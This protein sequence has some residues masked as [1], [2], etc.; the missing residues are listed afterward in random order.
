MCVYIIL[1]SL[2][3]IQSLALESDKERID[4]INT[5]IDNQ[6]SPMNEP[7]F[8]I[9]E[10]LFFPVRNIVEGLGGTIH[11]NP[12]DEQI[13]IETSSSDKLLF[14]IGMAEIQFNDHKYVM[15]VPSFI[16]EDR[17]YLPLRHVAEFMHAD[18]EWDNSSLTASLTKTPFYI[19]EEGDSLTSISTKFNTT[20]SLLLERNRSLNTIFHKGDI[21]KVLI[22]TIMEHKIVAPTVTV[23]TISMKSHPDYILLSKIIQVEAGY[24]SYESQV[25]VG[26]VIM[27]RVKDERFPNSIKEVIYQK[28]QFPPAHNGLLDESEPNESVL[29]AAEAVWNGENNVID[30]LY[31]YNPEV[32]KSI[33]WSKLTLVKEI[34]HHRYVK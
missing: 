2:L 6:P 12:E 3:P 21:L 11:W 27:N 28:G 13:T 33:S 18:V 32:T 16:H 9:N 23:E 25:A 34:G 7:A 29:R 4:H 14:T 5:L 26:S 24:E 10:R 15:D 8:L 22:P 1:L 31:F 17:V 19:V 30:A 20:E